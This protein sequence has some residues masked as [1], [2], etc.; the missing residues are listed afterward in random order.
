M[1]DTNPSEPDRDDDARQG[2]ILRGLDVGTPAADEA[3]LAT[4]RERSLA[5]FKQAAAADRRGTATTTRHE[6]AKRVHHQGGKPMSTLVLRGWVLAAAA[7]AAVVA[8]FNVGTPP[9]VSGAPFSQVLAELRGARSLELRVTRDGRTSDVWVQAPG[10]VRW[11]EA[12]GRYQVAAG[13]RLWKIDEA[14]D[15]VQAGDSP[16]YAGPTE[17]VD[18]LK[19]LADDV[20]DSTPL[21]NARPAGRA[22]YDGRECLVY[23][24]P[25]ATAHGRLE[26]E[27]FVDSQSGR[28]R[29]IIAASAGAGRGAPPAGEL[30][31]VA[32]NQPFDEAKFAVAK[33]LSEDGRIGKI[34]DAQGIVGLRP[35]SARRWTPIVRETS[36]RPG[37][38]VRTDIRGANAARVR[39]SS[40]IE[41]TLG[42]GSL[43]EC[44]SPL[45]ARLHAGEL[46]VNVARGKDDGGTKER[47]DGEKKPQNADAPSRSEATTFE[48]LGPTAGSEKFTSSGKSFLRLDRDGRFARLDDVKTWPKWLA[49][50]E[51][52]ASQES[53]GSLIV[54]LPDGRNEPLTVG[55]HKV[56]VEIRD[57]IARTTIEESFVNHTAARLEG[58]FHFPLPADASISGFGMWIGDELVEADV[59]EKQRAREIYETILRER[60]DPGL[61]EWTSGNLFK[62]RVFPIEPRSEKRVKIVYT[63]VLPLRGDE[64]RYTYGLRSD[65]LRNNPV[66]ELSL[67]VTVDSALPLA[68]VSCPTHPARTQRAENSARVEFAAQDYTPER[69]FEVVCKLGGRQSDVVVI[70]HRRGDDGYLLVE[71]MPPGIEGNWRREVL[72]DGEPLTFVLLC[73]TSGSM[74]SEKRKQ[75]AEFV[76]AL[77]AALGEKDRFLLA[78][79]DTS[80][81]WLDTESREATADRVAAARKF[82]NDRISL[83]WT[84]LDQAAK[85]VLAKAPTGAQVIY[86]GDGLVTAGDRKPA[87]FVNRFAKLLADRREAGKPVPAIHSVSVGNT[88]EA[89]V[90]RGIAGA[91]G[92]SSRAIAGERSP[93]A[94]AAELLEE[95]SQPGWRDLAVEFR[96]VKVAAVYPE[97]LPNVAAGTQQL[98]VARYLPEGKEQSGEIVVTGKRGDEAVRYAARIRFPDADAGNSFIPRLWARSHLDHLLAQGNSP[99]IQ[100]DVIR[101]SEEF[102]IITPLT[103][104]LVLET[105]ADR[106][107]FGVKRRYEMRDGERFFQ[108]GRDDASFELARQQMLRAGDWRIGMRRDVLRHLATLGRDPRIFA[109]PDSSHGRYATVGMSRLSRSNWGFTKLGSGSLELNGINTY[110]G[111]TVINGGTLSLEGFKMQAGGMAGAGGF[112]GELDLLVTVHEMSDLDSKGEFTSSAWDE[113][114]VDDSRAGNKEI[115]RKK[116]DAS[117]FG[118]E[119]EKHFAAR[120]EA[121]SAR[122]LYFDSSSSISESNGRWIM[123]LGVN[124]D[125]GLLGSIALDEAR[126]GPAGYPGGYIY[127][128]NESFTGELLSDRGGLAVTQSPLVLGGAYAG[129]PAAAWL[130]RVFPQLPGPPPIAVQQPKTEGWS[131]EALAVARSLVRIEAIRKLQGGVV[132]DATTDTFDPV[133]DRRSSRSGELTL[134]SPAAWLTRPQAGDGQRIV[135]YCDTK[136][137][138]IFSLAFGLGQTRAAVERDR[139]AF[140]PNSE[141]WTYQPLDEIYPATVGRVEPAGKDQVRL[142]IEY[143]DSN[144][145]RRFLIDTVRHVVLEVEDSADGKVSSSA[146][147]SDFIEVGGVLWVG[148]IETS[149]GRGRSTSRTT[150]DV[151]GLAPDAFAAR[152][153]EELAPRST[154]QFLRHPLPRLA[155][156]RRRTA[157]GSATF[158]DRIL[159]AVR[160]GTLQLTDEL[161]EHLSAAEKIA[162]DKPGVRWLRT[163]VL[164]MIRRNEVANRRHLGEADRLVAQPNP[165]DLFLA[166]FLIGLAQETAAPA[167]QLVLVERLRPVFERHPADSYA[168]ATLRDRLIGI[169]QQLSRTEEALALQKAQAEK[170]AWETHRQTGYARA[171]HE[172][173]R[174]VEAIAWLKQALARVV[175]RAEYDDDTL[176]TEYFSLLR[177][178]ARW[179]EL[180]A[181]SSKWIE[182]KPT[183]QT[184]YEH[185]LQALIYNNRID[186]AFALAEKWFGEACVEGRLAPDV[187]ARLNA[188]LRLAEGYLPGLYFQRSPRELRDAVAKVVRYFLRRDDGLAIVSQAMNGRFRDTEAADR[189][190]G[191][192]LRLLETDAAMLSVDQ[193]RLFVEMSQSA[194]LEFAEPLDGR[195]QMNPAEI[196]DATW[197]AI[198]DKLRT[199]WEAAVKVIDAARTAGGKPTNRKA[200]ERDI[201]LGETLESI[202]RAR[203]AETDW[204]PFLRRRVE[205]ADDSLRPQYRRAL[206]DAL[207]AR[208]WTE[209]V[210]QEA[211]DL[212][213]QL[214]ADV[215]DGAQ[216]GI[217]L[218]IR[219]PALHRLVDAMLTARQTAARK[220]LADADESDKLTR[221]DLAAKLAEFGKSAQTGL[222]ERLVGAAARL[223][224]QKDPLADWFEVE[225]AR[226]HIWLETDLDRVTTFC[227]SKL[228]NA[229]P[230][231][232]APLAAHAEPGRI[233]ERAYAGLLYSRALAIESY[234]AV[235]SASK[236]KDADSKRAATLLAYVDQA[237]AAAGTDD[238]RADPWRA[239]KFDLLVALDRPDDLERALREWV[240][241]ESTTAPWRRSLA[242]LTAERGN[243]DEA[244]G[245][246]EAIEKLR[247][248][249]ASD[250]RRLADWYLARNRRADH[251]RAVTSSY[252]HLDEYR[253]TQLLH[254]ARNARERRAGDGAP[255][256]PND[257]ALAVFRVL[258]EKAASPEN[259]LYMLRDE[260][261][262]ERDVRM[263]EMLPDAV[264]GRSPQQ[265]Y[266]LLI[267]A[268]ERV[269]YDLRN[270][271]AADAI[272][273]RIK[274]LRTSDRSITDLRAL[275]LLEAIV[276]RQSAEVLNQPGPHVD[277]CLA[278]LKRA[279]DRQWGAGEPRE[280]AVYLGALGKLPAPAL[281]EE[282]L[283]ELAALREAAKVAEKRAGEEPAA[284]KGSAATPANGRDRLV[285]TAELA[286]LLYRAYNRRDEALRT[287]EAELTAYE[288]AHDGRLPYDDHEVLDTYLGLLSDAGRHAAVEAMLLKEIAGI[289][290]EAQQA[291]YYGR[292][293]TYYNEALRHGGTVSLGSGEKL[294]RALVDFGLRRI[295]KENDENLRQQGV[296]HI[297]NTFE[298]ALRLKLPGVDK[299][300]EEFA[301]VSMPQILKRQTN[302]YGSTAYVPAAI[303]GEGL[304][305]KAALRYLVEVLERRPDAV[306]IGWNTTWNQLGNYLAHY[307]TAATEKKLDVAELEPRVLAIAV[308]ELKR[309]LREVNGRNREI[310]YRHHS[311]F[312][313]AKADAFAAAADEVY[314]EQKDSG[315][316]VVYIADYVRHGLDLRPRSVEMLL[317]AHADGRLDVDGRTQLIN[318]LHEDN[319]HAESIPIL[320]ALVALEPDV[321]LY[322]AQLMR[323]YH[324]AKR[325][326]QLAE[327]LKQ[328]DA[329]FSA[330]GRRTDANLAELAKAASDCELYREAV[331]YFN[332][333]ITARRRRDDVPAVNDDSLS[334]WHQQLAHA[335]SQLGRTREAVEAASGAVVAWSL[336][337]ER[338]RGAVDSLRNALSAAKDLDEYVKLRDDEAARTGQDSPLVRKLLGEVYTSRSRHDRA[339]AQFEIARDLQPNDREV[340]Q[341]LIAAYDALGR[342]D[343]ATKQLL[344]Q[345][346]FDRHD[347][348]LYEQLVERLKN[349]EAE[350]ERA[351]TSLVEA[352]PEEAEN[353]QAAAELRQKQNRWKEAIDAWR[354]V[355][356][357]RRLEPT[358]LIGLA[359]AQV[360][361]KQWDAAKATLDR[362]DKTEWPVRFQEALR[363]VP[364][365]RQA[366]PK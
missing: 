334:T 106:E 258:F 244:I 140:T 69:D 248:L 66:R 99:A 351:A 35:M 149:D 274:V 170:L 56:S 322:R 134:Y 346:D 82:L 304:G 6:G 98:L 262:A 14:A 91:S 159:M 348:K 142:A 49:G 81:A 310:Y 10:M 144:Y 259:Y 243:L 87:S 313:Q 54:S 323:A 51:G 131:H 133:W 299:R 361:E 254:A 155:D 156:A 68:E 17:P 321:M 181:F 180:L 143:V 216:P 2:A 168:A 340:S 349:D 9:E 366:L 266:K 55:Y 138:G 187:Q 355:A 235:R 96:G 213:G 252:R 52:T 251:D 137:R 61:L 135:N 44:I 229:P 71:L 107:R 21:L 280:M 30:R 123:G 76:A 153:Q 350:A 265:I 167:E 148:K 77:L 162:V 212:L 207:I 84:D 359:E 177:S 97:K 160:A 72:P 8:W 41:L 239:L 234:L 268:K 53:L 117:E 125:T 186:D 199:R 292:L 27:A 195:R 326:Q 242:L 178:R 256:D 38:W 115:L 114:L 285:I 112:G 237:I 33:S 89:T 307:R 58:V 328:T 330:G 174:P 43:L 339:A 253:L 209:A 62:A 362:L 65:L 247:L 95:L 241:T 37:D 42:P 352:G 215:P 312:W 127:A 238:D 4:L 19:L 208:P 128:G 233:I 154:T 59:V 297:R 201:R 327:L 336:R 15:T 255:S 289:E 110:S 48:L 283:R 196:P 88:Y 74:D 232:E 190:R 139:I 261:Q 335:H 124:S 343:E 365:L 26:V 113:S 301:F 23:R 363:K 92:G 102:H 260:Y 36:L 320:E 192:M 103:S 245:L 188:A 342:K 1:N 206:F 291:W 228:G 272:V 271:A 25:L 203:F 141:A 225:L 171:L 67:S 161:L 173:G 150:Y 300:L 290:H 221:T 164:G 118:A 28:L 130:T 39:L 315:R 269:L 198:A 354:E 356:E 152:F 205:T 227:R 94:V 157:D 3:M 12:P 46:Q 165:D 176:R 319:R 298:H 105:D 11:D 230:K 60:R 249:G 63:Q 263:L 226:L 311:N 279:F 284:G 360:H 295:E 308:G 34:S 100:D 136:E 169:Y 358:G 13:S 57:Q 50:F 236:A 197:R 126:V 182:R 214:P 294:F 204:L 80:T 314:R 246:F 257:M 122:D 217:R 189:I 302:Q 224:E 40:E 24:A 296:E 172:S 184:G 364:N 281:V 191:E 318:W 200:V 250:Y 193:V 309:D 324:H 353:H 5:A 337:H 194:R 64:Y 277:A 119:S 31:L 116:L 90:L 73:D 108:E 288:Q 86:I 78:A 47:G 276:E 132:I 93:Q 22:P 166:G 316:T 220:G 111:G 120:D 240:R 83:G 331:G 121:K 7:S 183:T 231:P 16:W 303:I 45:Q 293:W 175:E 341:A 211:F 329:H 185:H 305:P 20:T 222:A 163:V 145:V 70:P 278:A 18:L 101:L 344:A 158:D 345:I 219:V 333:A 287:L 306:E 357:L 273:A 275:D 210:E 179:E 347:L 29:G 267:A 325:P 338:R 151:K 75:Q 218:A 129:R 147:Y 146:R 79:T 282:Q 270:E 32:M 202:Y 286:K 317:L 104:L 223:A 332:E 85:S 109:P 264:L